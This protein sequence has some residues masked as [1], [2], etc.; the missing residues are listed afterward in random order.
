MSGSERKGTHF[1]QNLTSL[2]VGYFTIDVH[3]DREGN[4]VRTSE[5]P[6]LEILRRDVLDALPA[7]SETAYVRHVCLPQDY[8]IKMDG[9][10][11]EGVLCRSNPKEA[12]TNVNAV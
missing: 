7:I 3:H 1:F 2:G 4:P 6:D 11:Q 9:M 10:K 5:Q 8:T 12:T